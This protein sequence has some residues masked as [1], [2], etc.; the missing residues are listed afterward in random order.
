MTTPESST[1]QA[2]LH[3][4][5]EILRTLPAEVVIRFARE[6]E[7]EA[8][9]RGLITVDLYRLSLTEKMNT[10]TWKSEKE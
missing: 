7:Q 1:K 10:K 3:A 4:I 9:E 6:C 2:T 8:L 5:M